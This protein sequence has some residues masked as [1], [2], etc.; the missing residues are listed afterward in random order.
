MKLKILVCD[1]EN[2]ARWI[3]CSGIEIGP[4][5]AQLPLNWSFEYVVLSLGGG[6]YEAAVV[7]LWVENKKEVD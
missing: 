4:T 5:D 3:E 6:E 2:K 1:V 7:G